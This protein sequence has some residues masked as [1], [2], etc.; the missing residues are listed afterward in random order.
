MRIL[1]RSLALAF[2][3]AAS[4]STPNTTEAATCGAQ[5]GICN[6]DCR[7]CFSDAG[8]PTFLGRKQ[9]CMCGALCP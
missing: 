9:F 1:L 5:G 6:R 4:I 8:C 3:V 2:V 7:P